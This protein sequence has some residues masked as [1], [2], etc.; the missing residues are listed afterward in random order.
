MNW[1]RRELTCGRE[2]RQSRVNN[3][4]GSPNDPETWSHLTSLLLAQRALGSA[5]PCTGE[6][7]TTCTQKPSPLR[8]RWR[9]VSEPDEVYTQK[10]GTLFA[11]EYRAAG[12]IV[13]GEEE[14]RGG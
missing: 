1:L 10:S 4:S 3:P 14:P 6:A 11:D 13:F 7:R 5:P 12:E 2:L 8:G 9:S